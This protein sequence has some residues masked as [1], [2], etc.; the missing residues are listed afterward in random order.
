MREGFT[1]T[2]LHSSCDFDIIARAL[3]M[4]RPRVACRIGMLVLVAALAHRSAGTAH[5]DDTPQVEGRTEAEA[6]EAAQTHKEITQLLQDVQHK[7]GSD[8]VMLEGHLLGHAVRGGSIL[9]ATVT[10]AGVEAREGKRFLT[11]KVE[12]GIIYNDAEVASTLR[13]VR[14]WNDVVEKTLRQFHTLTVPA[15]GIAVTLG[16]NHKSY[17]DE[18][19]LRAH[20]HET[21]GQAEA[22]AFYLLLSD[23]GELIAQRLT[24]QQLIDRSVVLVD[25]TPTRITLAASDGPHD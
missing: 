18:A 6:A 5:A 25:G 24:S 13:P 19:D 3:Q 7:Y 2:A 20:L 22:A 9:E 15:D 10:V 21:H 16:Y 14:V 12:T 8:A 1:E 17:R 11:F 23:V 4:T